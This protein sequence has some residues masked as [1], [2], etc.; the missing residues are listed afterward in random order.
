[1]KDLD[2][3]IKFYECYYWSYHRLT[4]NYKS[5]E[6]DRL[7]AE[8]SNS[9]FYFESASYFKGEETDTSS[10]LLVSDWADNLISEIYYSTK[11]TDTSQNSPAGQDVPNFYIDDA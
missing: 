7:R 2:H 11:S 4:Y 6:G 3:V 1:M 8:V 9:S 5:T 10:I